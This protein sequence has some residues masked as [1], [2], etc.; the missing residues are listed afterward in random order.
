MTHLHK[1]WPHLTVALVA[2]VTLSPL[3]AHAWA[4][5]HMP[6]L[7]CDG[8]DDE[9]DLDRVPDAGALRIRSTHEDLTCAFSFDS[10]VSYT[11]FDR[12]VFRGYDGD[13]TEGWDVAFCIGNG[14]GSSGVTCGTPEGTSNSFEDWWTEI[15][16]APSYS[17]SSYGQTHY[18][19]VLS[20]PTWSYI[21]SYSLEDTD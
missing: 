13:D 15:I 21:T 9:D 17:G 11:T 2:I 12:A 16:D 1:Y 14:T 7:M 10:A 19:R 18:L 4:W 3:P 6:G 8:V 20:A 5:H